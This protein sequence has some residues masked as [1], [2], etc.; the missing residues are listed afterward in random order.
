MYL[1]K[2][3]VRGGPGA[4]SAPGIWR[5]PRSCIEVGARGLRFMVISLRLS[6]CSPPPIRSGQYPSSVVSGT[7]ILLSGPSILHYAGIVMGQSCPLLCGIWFSIARGLASVCDRA[8]WYGVRSTREA[9]R[10]GEASYQVGAE[11]VLPCEGL[12][13]KSAIGK[14][15]GTRPIAPCSLVIAARPITAVYP[16]ADLLASAVSVRGAWCL[17]KKG[18]TPPCRRSRASPWGETADQSEIGDPTSSFGFEADLWKLPNHHV[19]PS[20]PSQDPHIPSSLNSL[21][22]IQTSAGTGLAAACIAGHD[23]TTWPG[24]A[25]PRR[26]C[27]LPADPV[28]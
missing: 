23:R 13:L 17:V 1:A 28:G 7:L 12:N 21:N 24:R 3:P 25:G 6:R 22:P 4:S 27:Q 11:D 9:P 16:A 15:L 19:Q 8:R 18:Q 5:P 2:L 10:S 20:P 26:S 14:R